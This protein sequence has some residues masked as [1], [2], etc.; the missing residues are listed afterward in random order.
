MFEVGGDGIFAGGE[1]KWCCTRCEVGHD[2]VGAGAEQPE[3]LVDRVQRAVGVALG[4]HAQ[5]Q[6]A[7]CR[8]A[9]P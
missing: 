3:L 8:T 2:E 7:W 1:G 9:I 5:H 4:E 6:L